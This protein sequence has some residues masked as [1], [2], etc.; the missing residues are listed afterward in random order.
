M[1]S[2]VV[3]PIVKSWMK[4]ACQFSSSR[5]DSREIWPFVQ[6]AMVTGKRQIIGEVFPTV[7]PRDDV[8]NVKWQRL[9]F[10][11]Q[12]AIF[13]ATFRSPSDQLAQPRV[14]Q[15][16]FARASALRALA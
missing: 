11:A 5:I 10:F 12:M 2:K 16:A 4:Q 1:I 7:L 14:H 15:A 3:T 8:F 9:L 13:T 6:V